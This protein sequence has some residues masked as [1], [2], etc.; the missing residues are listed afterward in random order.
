MQRLADG[1]EVRG[2]V[3]Q[4]GCL[5]GGNAIADG[6]MGD[7]RIDL[8]PA[9]VGGNDSIELPREGNRRLSV[10]GRTVPCKPAAGEA[11]EIGEQFIGIMRPVAGVA[12]RLRRK[13]VFEGRPGRHYMLQEGV[14]PACFASL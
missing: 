3:V 5:G 4:P 8:R 14:F 1:D 7:C 9:C 12:R 2:I 10:T 13:V 6:G 11:R